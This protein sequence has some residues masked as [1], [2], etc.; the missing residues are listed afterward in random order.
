MELLLELY[1]KKKTIHWPNLVQN[2]LYINLLYKI[3]IRETSKLTSESIMLPTRVSKYHH[4]NSLEKQ[5]TNKAQSRCLKEH[6]HACTHS[7]TQYACWQRLMNVLRSAAKS[8][9]NHFSGLWCPAGSLQHKWA[10]W[11]YISAQEHK[12]NHKTGN[13]AP[14][15]DT[16]KC[17]S[18]PH[19][20]QT[21]ILRLPIGP[22]TKGTDI[23]CA[24]ETVIGN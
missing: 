6:K 9:E 5:A 18:P 10:S 14:T 15:P 11:Q 21:W 1:L 4:I 17:T 2:V 23:Y 8:R 19:Q 24:G 20:K 16:E 7:H 22:V 13:R 12:L 3:K